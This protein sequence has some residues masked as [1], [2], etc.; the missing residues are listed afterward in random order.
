MLKP[1]NWLLML[2]MLVVADF[3]AAAAAAGACS[4]CCVQPL[5]TT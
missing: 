1:A 3:A 5:A 4:T 2:N